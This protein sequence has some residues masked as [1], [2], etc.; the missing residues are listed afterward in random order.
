MTLFQ[1][2]MQ[3]DQDWTSLTELLRLDC[4]H[5]EN[6]NAHVLPHKLTY[7]EQLRQVDE[8]LRRIQYIEDI[9]S[10][11]SVDL[12]APKSLAQ[13][14]N[15]MEIIL[16][17]KKKAAANVAQDIVGEVR[18]QETFMREQN[19]L[20]D[21]AVRNFRQMLCHINVYK[22]VASAIGVSS[23][24]SLDI[25]TSKADQVRESLISKEV[26][27]A[28]NV[29]Y[30]GGTISQL[31][32]PTMKRLLF[33]ATRGR[34]I[35]STFE[36]EVS[37]DDKLR[38]DNFHKAVVGYVIMFQD[39]GHTR[40]IV[41]RICQSFAFGD[42]RYYLEA[43]PRTVEQDLKDAHAQKQQLREL[44]VQSKQ[45]FFDYLTSYRDHDQ[46]SIFQTYK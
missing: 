29:V 46:I 33:R 35:L 28:T 20:I 11:Y 19:K 23:G 36:L 34:A 14:D 12:H 17:E 26:L 4:L 15:A 21:A 44:I 9:H 38:G 6:L 16:R 41:T 42:S 13:F 24:A 3:R 32:E 45:T 39:A 30:F 40:Q 1:V 25:E 31:E 2:A 5:F 27:D 7:C 43:Q 22:Q 8:T 10:K 37:E 18:E